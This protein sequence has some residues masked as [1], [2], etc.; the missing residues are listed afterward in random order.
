VEA[1]LEAGYRHFDTA[2]A[3]HNEKELGKAL[4]ASGLPRGELF[5]TSKLWNSDQGHGLAKS[6]CLAS[7]ER[8]GLG[9][10]DLYLLHWPVSGRSQA[11]WEEMEGLV[12]EGLAKAA[13]VSNF[14]LGQLERLLRES[15]FKPLVDQVEIH[16]HHS[17]EALAKLCRASGVEMTAYAPLA[18]GQLNNS[19]N[20][21]RVAAR[22]NRTVPQVILRWHLQKGR[23]VIPKSGDPGRILENSKIFDFEL[24]EADIKILDKQNQGRSVLKPKFELDAH[25]Y[26]ID[27]AAGSE[28]SPPRYSS[29]AE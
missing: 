12:A 2:P 26:V 18:R 14:E 4:A 6:A 25:G 1:A 15:S 16:P 23:G 21:A 19:Q 27:E 28:Y 11:A 22:L 8:L 13:G 20:L 9:H 17:K 29:Q 5:V 3:Y 24:D 10:L 7:L